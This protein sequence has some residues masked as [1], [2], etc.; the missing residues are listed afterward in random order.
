[1]EVWGKDSLN[2]KFPPDTARIC[3]TPGGAAVFG[4]ETMPVKLSPE[5]RTRSNNAYDHWGQSLDAYEQ[6]VQV[7]A[8]TSK[9]DA[10]LHDATSHPLSAD[11]MA[12]YNLFRGKANC[13]SCH[14]DGRSNSQ[15]SGEVD[16]G[17]A[18][19]VAPLFT[20]FTYNNLGLPM[21]LALPWYSENH[22]DQFG[23]TANP[24]GVG[25]I[26]EGVGLF[27]AGHYGAPP[28]NFSWQALI[29][30]FVGKFQTSTL[31]NAG[32]VPPPTPPNTIPFVKAY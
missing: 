29:P 28:P 32:Q 21:N 16:T 3:A 8:F 6:S 31:R 13:N 30:F 27:L 14:L 20:D 23:F 4:S 15:A 26:D 7:S 12:G 2:I 17:M 25:F 1:E 11:E 9:F 19:D 10:F 18:T 24:L 5:D 22:P